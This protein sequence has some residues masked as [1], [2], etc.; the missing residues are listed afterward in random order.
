MQRADLVHTTSNDSE[1]RFVDDRGRQCGCDIHGQ[2]LRLHPVSTD[3]RVRP[4][5][6]ITIGPVGFITP[7]SA[8]LMFLVE[9]MIELEI[10]LI[11]LRVLTD[12]EQVRG[13][14]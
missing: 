11:T 12:T 6:R 5:R 14:V 9:V 2:N 8:H 4:T 7:R 13:A 1:T 10:D 3:P